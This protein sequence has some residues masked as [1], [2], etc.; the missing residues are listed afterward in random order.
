MRKNSLSERKTGQIIIQKKNI[1]F[2]NFHIFRL[3]HF[4]VYLLT[5]SGIFVIVLY[6]S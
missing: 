3:Q 4:S 5:M 6:A 2:L 1:S